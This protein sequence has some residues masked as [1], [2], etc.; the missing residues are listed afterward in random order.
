MV[1]F[2]VKGKKQ[3]EK[4]LQRLPFCLLRINKCLYMILKKTKLKVTTHY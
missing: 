4:V 2:F 3:L 1:P